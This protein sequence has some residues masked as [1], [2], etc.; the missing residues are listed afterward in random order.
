MPGSWIP[1]KGI[2]RDN[3]IICFFSKIPILKWILKLL[4][5]DPVN[6][7]WLSTS[8]FAMFKLFRIDYDL[9]IPEAGMWGNLVCRIIRFFKGTPYVD[10]AH[11]RYGYWEF[12]SALQKPDAYVSP[13]DYN[14]K[15]IKKKFKKINAVVI[16]HGVDLKKFHPEIPRASLPL[17]KPIFLCVGALD[18]VKRIH[19]AIQ[20]VSRLSQGSLAVIGYGQLKEELQEFGQ[21]MLG[22]RFL[23]TDIPPSHLPEYYAACDAY[24]LPSAHEAFGMTF[25]EAMACNK[26]V[27][28]CQDEIRQDVIN[29]A[30]ILCDCSNIEQYSHALGRAVHENFGTRPRKQAENFGWDETA[31]KYDELF[32]SLINLDYS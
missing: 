18:P 17:E 16:P 29:D 31:K 12:L 27:V 7:E 1:V 30:G 21:K 15:I 32:K 28:S 23:L 6:V 20:A 8:F 25:L 26:P 3:K 4:L 2:S 11:S 14:H 22:K 13:N 24:T 9:I 19:L 10:I 5:L